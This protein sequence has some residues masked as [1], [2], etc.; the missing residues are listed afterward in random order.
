M[1]VSPFGAKR[2]VIS[3]NSDAQFKTAR[4]LGRQKT[5]RVAFYFDEISDD[6]SQ[7]F[8]IIN[9]TNSADPAHS[10]SGSSPPKLKS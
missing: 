9:I 10:G 4:H 6:L 8:Q 3:L 7:H 2:N 1:C 5:G